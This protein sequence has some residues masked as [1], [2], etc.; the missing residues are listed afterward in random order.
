MTWWESFER[1]SIFIVFRDCEC[2]KLF[3]FFGVQNCGELTTDCSESL[4]PVQLILKML[5]PKCSQ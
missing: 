4:L 3:F 2:A 5:K 1:V